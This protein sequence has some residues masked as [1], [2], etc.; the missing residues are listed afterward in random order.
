LES[1]GMNPDILRHNLRREVFLCALAKNAAKLLTGRAVRPNV[2]DVVTAAEVS[3]EARQRWIIPRAQRRPG[4]KD[5]TLEDT[6][7]LIRGEAQPPAAIEAIPEATKIN[8]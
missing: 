7:R 6:L 5:W 3:V 8:M 1:L 4:F 2:R